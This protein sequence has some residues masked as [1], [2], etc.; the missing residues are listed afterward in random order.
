MP[1]EEIAHDKDE[2]GV[3]GYYTVR[4]PS[5]GVTAEL[6]A[7]NRTGV[8]RFHYPSHRCG[9]VLRTPRRVAG[10]QLR[11]RRSRSETTTPRSPG[12]R[13]AAGSAVRTTSTRC[14]S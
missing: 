1:S 12:R 11:R 5:A 6:T 10:R 14:T 13:P 2:R 8:G 7:T 3:P 9:A 4:L